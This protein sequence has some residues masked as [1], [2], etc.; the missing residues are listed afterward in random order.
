MAVTG[1][2]LTVLAF[3][4]RQGILTWDGMGFAAF[5]CLGCV[6]IAPLPDIL[7]KEWMPGLI[8]N[9]SGRALDQPVV[10]TAVVLSSSVLII[11]WY[12]ISRRIKTATIFDLTMGALVPMLAGMVGTAVAFPALSFALT[13][14]SL[15]SLM[16]GANRV[17]WHARKQ[18]SR[19]TAAGLAFSGAMTIIVLGPTTLLGLFDQ[20]RLALLLLGVVGGFLLPQIHVMFGP[21]RANPTQDQ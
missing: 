19:F 1:L 4:L 9:L 18:N 10:L 20:P 6:L 11:L 7:L 21:T 12:L 17:Y 13:W 5:V 2:F 14:P 16:A 15:F 8:P 3:G